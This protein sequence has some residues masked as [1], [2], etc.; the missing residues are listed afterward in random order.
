MAERLHIC[1][2]ILAAGGSHRFGA[3]DKLTAQLYG[4]MLGYHICDTLS[5][6][7]FCRSV[8]IASTRA[9]ACAVGWQSAGF[10]I[11]INR[12]AALGMSTSVA[13]AAKLAQESEADGLLICLA[14]MPLVPVEHCARIL[15]LFRDQRAATIIASHDGDIASPPAIFGKQHFASLSKLRGD[16]GA[17]SLLKKAKYVNLDSAYLIDIDRPAIL[18]KLNSQRVDNRG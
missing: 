10:D 6:F 3:D 15:S 11:A 1:A 18:Q 16:I 14:D 13:L 4:K 2:A 7:R 17:Q 5:H 12:K 8:V 9:H